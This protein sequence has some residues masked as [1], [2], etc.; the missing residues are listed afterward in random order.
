MKSIIAKNGLLNLKII[1]VVVLCG[2]FEE[3]TLPQT[4]HRGLLIRVLM[5]DKKIAALAP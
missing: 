4:V 5:S 1:V 2:I 3:D